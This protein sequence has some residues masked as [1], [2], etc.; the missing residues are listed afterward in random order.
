MSFN[1]SPT[2]CRI[3]FTFQLPLPGA[4]IPADNKYK[5]DLYESEW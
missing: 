5:D 4:N 1:S 3:K 2:T